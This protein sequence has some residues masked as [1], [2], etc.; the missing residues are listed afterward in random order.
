[1]VVLGLFG[2]TYLGSTLVL[3][4]AEASQALSRARRLLRRRSA[5]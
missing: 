3:G 1:L 5:L 2:A 4:V